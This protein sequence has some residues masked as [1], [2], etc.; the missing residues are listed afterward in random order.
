MS[1]QVETVQDIPQTGGPY[2]VL[3]PC[4]AI[5]RHVWLTNTATKDP[6][7]FTGTPPLLPVPSLTAVAAVVATAARVR[8][9]P[10]MG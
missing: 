5:R 8:H 2:N 4:T 10:M 3:F 7:D 6:P 1:I 9:A